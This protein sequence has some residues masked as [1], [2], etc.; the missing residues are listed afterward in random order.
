MALQ[1]L[2]NMDEIGGYGVV[3]ILKEE[4]REGF[5][6]EYVEG[7]YSPIIVDHVDNRIEFKIQ[8]GPI[9]EVGVNGCQVDTLIHAALL[10]IAGLNENLPCPENGNAIAHLKSALM[11]LQKRTR[12]RE[13][14]GV[15]GTSRD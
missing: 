8:N 10:I 4:D 2:E 12:D 3:H 14:R 11:E 6:T 7:K 15:E 1:T 13:Q 5:R 9:K